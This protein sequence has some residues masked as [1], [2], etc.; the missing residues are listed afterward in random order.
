MLEEHEVD[1][2]WV[3][4][5]YALDS[6][7]VNR[8]QISVV[9]VTCEGVGNENLPWV[10]DFAEGYVTY[11]NDAAVRPPADITVDG[12]SEFTNYTCRATVTNSGGVS[13][14]SDGYEFMT[15]EDGK[16]NLLQ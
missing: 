13:E 4:L 9:N 10:V 1:K 2:T 16:Y 3:Q 8:C 14:E 11:P 12:L 7:D 5:R 15:G 6:Y